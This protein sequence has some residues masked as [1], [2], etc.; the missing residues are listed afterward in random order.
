MSHTRT[1]R[2]HLNDQNIR[3][4]ISFYWLKYL[5]GDIF[6]GSSPGSVSSPEPEGSQNSHQSRIDKWK[7]KHQAMLKLA[8]ESKHRGEQTSP[9]P[10]LEQSK[11]VITLSEKEEEKMKE[12][13]RFPGR[14]LNTALVV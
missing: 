14:S 2:Y 8:A 10:P 12:N 6:A 3:V 5:F 9:S 11:L 4:K 13:S 7:A 1:N